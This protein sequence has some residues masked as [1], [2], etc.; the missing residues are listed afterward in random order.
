MNIYVKL[1]K[2]HDHDHHDY[3]PGEYCYTCKWEIKT[4]FFSY[5]AQ[6]NGLRESKIQYLY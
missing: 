3:A 4:F 6:I 5:Q 1:I 2:D